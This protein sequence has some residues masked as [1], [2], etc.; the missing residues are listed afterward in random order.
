[1]MAVMILVFA[2]IWGSLSAQFLVQ[3]ILSFIV[4][5][6]CLVGIGFSKVSRTMNSAGSLSSLFQSIIF[7]ILFVGGNYIS[8]R[9]IS[10]DWGIHLTGVEHRLGQWNVPMPAPIS[11]PKGCSS[12]AAETTR[13]SAQLGATF[14]EPPVEENP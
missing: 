8:T 12:Q 3:T 4:A 1:M 5:V 11:A 9:Y 14:A 6:L 13:T 10:Y 2:V 7:G